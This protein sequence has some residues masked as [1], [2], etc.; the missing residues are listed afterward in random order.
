MDV[1]EEDREKISQ[2]LFAFKGDKYLS[3]TL[4]LIMFPMSLA[5]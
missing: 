4:D 3:Q 5:L 1:S 2:K